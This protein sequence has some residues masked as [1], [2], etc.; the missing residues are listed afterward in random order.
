MPKVAMNEALSALQEALEGA[1]ELSAEER[2][3]LYDLKGEIE[4][5]LERTEEIHGAAGQAVG[6]RAASLTM[7]EELE[8]RKPGLVAVL[9]R[10]A[11]VMS[12]LGM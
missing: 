1:E 2:D 12:S 9:N 5:V 3:Q 4:L 8:A 6:E 10:L 11:E 7:L